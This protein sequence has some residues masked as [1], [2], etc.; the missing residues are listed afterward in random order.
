MRYAVARHPMEQREERPSLGYP[1]L[2]QRKT[3][4]TA[5]KLRAMSLLNGRSAKEEDHV[6]FWRAQSRPPPLLSSLKV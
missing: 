3:T 1:E 6:N 5:A 2:R 4:S